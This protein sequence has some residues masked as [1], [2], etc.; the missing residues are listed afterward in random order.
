MKL[1]RSLKEVLK[2]VGPMQQWASM[3]GQWLSVHTYKGSHLLRT[4]IIGAGKIHIC[5]V[6]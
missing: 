6:P 1:E 3:L 5:T 2:C 4:Y